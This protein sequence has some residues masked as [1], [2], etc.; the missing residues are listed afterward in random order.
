[1][2]ALREQRPESDGDFDLVEIVAGLRALRTASQKRRYRGAAPP[3]PSREIIVDMVE[4]LVAALY[5]RHFGPADLLPARRRRVHR[6]ARSMGALPPSERQIELELRSPRNGRAG[7]GSIRRAAPAT[8]SK[9]FAAAICRTCARCSTATSGPH[10]TGDP[11]AKSID[12]IIF[13]FPGF[14]AIARHRLAHELYDLGVTMIARIIAED[15]HSRDRHRHPPGRR[16]RR[17][18]F[19]RPRHRASSSAR[20]RSSAATCASIRR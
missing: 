13:C 10:S 17:A 2:S 1:M 15:A 8:S 7:A 12:E 20:R 5:P 9:D 4:S 3:L 19:H 6:S 18:V 11:S 16:D 14:A